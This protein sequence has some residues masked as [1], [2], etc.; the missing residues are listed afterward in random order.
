MET[1][2]SHILIGAFT[3]IFFLFALLFALWIGRISLD[4]EWDEYD[5]LFKEAVTGLTV[6][7][8]VQYNGIQIGEVRHLSLLP[9][10]PR[11]VI[12][13]VRITADTPVKTDTQASLTFTGLTGVAIIQLSGGSPNA[14]LLITQNN[15]ADAP[16]RIIAKDSTIQKLLTSSA[17]ITTNINIILERLSILLQTE[18][19]E[20]IAQTLVHFEK[21]TGVLAQ[22]D[23]TM[24]NLLENTAQASQTLQVVLKRA[25]HLILKL[26]NATQNAQQVLNHDIKT[27]VNQL[28]TTLESA[29]QLSINAN[30]ILDDNRAAIRKF[31][32]QDITHISATAKK[33]GDTMQHL[34]QLI[35]E[36]QNSIIMQ[37]ISADRPQE[38][39]LP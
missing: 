21:I 16:P 10:D 27:M 30:S 12:A 11:Q 18:N 29:Q 22:H 34:E 5:I 28:N 37:Q 9:E 24:S 6:G 36:L 14:P 8:A 33:F 20:H 1:R 4:R 17:D 26:D 31:S 23:Q 32:Q 15:I 35:N 7:G 39:E 3:L 25:N 19:L 2:A 13:R 38:Y